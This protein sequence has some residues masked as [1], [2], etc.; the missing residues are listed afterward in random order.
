MATVEYLEL[1][2]LAGQAGWTVVLKNWQEVATNA[3][4]VGMNTSACSW[5]V[6]D[7]LQ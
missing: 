7:L 6:T 3:D 4:T 2:G 5:S 1:A